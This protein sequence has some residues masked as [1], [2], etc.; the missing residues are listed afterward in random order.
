MTK[1]DIDRKFVDKN[2]EDIRF[3]SVKLGYV[4]PDMV[5]IMALIHKEK[6]NVW[7]DGAMFGF[8]EGFRLML[9]EVESITGGHDT[10]CFSE[11]MNRYVDEVM[12]KLIEFLPAKAQTFLKDIIGEADVPIMSKYKAKHLMLLSFLMSSYI[13]ADF[14]TEMVDATGMKE[15]FEHDADKAQ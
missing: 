14:M 7:G 10:R 6:G 15:H 8:C 2:F 1:R 4:S 12:D 5:E 13:P 11:T 3:K 9:Q